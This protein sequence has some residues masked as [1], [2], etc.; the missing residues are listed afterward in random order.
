MNELRFFLVREL[1]ML[2]QLD[3]PSIQEHENRK[4]THHFDFAHV[5]PSPDAGFVVALCWQVDDAQGHKV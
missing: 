5:D 2:I 1:C 3:L 4:A